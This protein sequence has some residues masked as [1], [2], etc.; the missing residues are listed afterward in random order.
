MARLLM[1]AKW[2]E[3]WVYNKSSDSKRVTDMKLTDW[4]MSLDLYDSQTTYQ[5]LYLK[6]TKKQK[7][8]LVL[9]M[10]S[11]RGVLNLL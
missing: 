10:W 9:S 3:R 7:S 4:V 1:E 6:K 8:L 2:G 11:S 5:G